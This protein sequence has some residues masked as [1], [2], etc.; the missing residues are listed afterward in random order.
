VACSTP[1]YNH[2][3]FKMLAFIKSIVSVIW[4]PIG[5]VLATLKG[6]LQSLFTD[7]ILKIAKYVFFALILLGIA[8]LIYDTF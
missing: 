5:S 7:L 6:R 3:S 1:F 8:I 4:M 2:W